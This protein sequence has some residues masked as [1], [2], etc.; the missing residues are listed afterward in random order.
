M[1]QPP[2]RDSKN[3]VSAGRY[4][5]SVRTLDA[6]HRQ[7]PEQRLAR[8]RRCAR[9]LARRPSPPRPPVSNTTTSPVSG[10]SIS[11]RPTLR[12]RLL[13]RIAHGHRDDVVAARRDPQRLLVAA[14]PAPGSPRP[15]TPPPAGAPRGRGTPA[16]PSEVR[17][18]A[19]A[20]TTGSP[21][22]TRRTC[23]LPFFG[24]TNFSTSSVKTI[25]PTRSLLRMAE[26]ATTAAS[27]AASSR[28]SC[29]PDPKR[30]EADMSTSR[31]TVI[32]RS[33]VNSLM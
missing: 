6:V 13:Q 21:L 31:S 12:Q 29:P 18:A 26:K 5:R 10:S 17:L 28:F 19:S 30:P 9:R 4:G 22:T 1:P 23:F 24:G 16:R 14:R 25:S 15:G 2:A 27:S 7:A 20:R 11:T 3:V 8:L 32:S 33:S